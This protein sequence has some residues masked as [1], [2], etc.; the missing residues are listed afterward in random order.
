MKP[1]KKYRISFLV[2]MFC[3]VNILSPAQERFNKNKS[4]QYRVIH[5]T[6]QDGLADNGGNVMLKD[7]KGFLWV[8][9][10]YGE[11]CRFDGATFKKYIPNPRIK[12]M[13]NSGGIRALVED[14]LHHIWIGTSNGISKYDMMADTFSNFIPEFD[15]ININSTIIPFWSTADKVYCLESEV[16]IISYNIHSHKKTILFDR[17]ELGKLFIGGVAINSIILDAVSNSFWMLHNEQLGEAALWQIS[18]DDGKKQSYKWPCYSSNI[19]HRHTAEAIRFDDRRNSIWINSGEGLLE[20]SLIDKQ[21][22]RIAAMNE[23]VKLKDYDRYVGIDLDKFGRVWLATKPKGILIYDPQTESLEQLF[24]DPVLQEQTGEHNLHLYCDRDG[25]TWVSDYIGKGIYELLPFNSVIQRYDANPEIKGSL[26]NGSI[27]TTVAAENGKMWI[28]TE[29]GL[30]I[31][32][33]SK[34]K[35]EVLREKDLPGIKGLTIAPLYVDTVRQKAWIQARSPGLNKQNEMEMY[36][37][38]MQTRKCRPITFSDGLKKLNTFSIEPTWINPYQNGFLLFDERHGVF[39][40]RGD[41]LVA[42][43]IIPFKASVGRFVLGNDHL[44]FLQGGGSGINFTFEKINGSWGKKAH[45]L[46]SLPWLSMLYNGIDHSYW[47]SFKYELVHYD[48]NFKI[49][50]KYGQEVGYNGSIYNMQ[51]DNEGNLWFT[52]VLNQIGR[53]NKTTGIITILTEAEGFKKQTFTWFSPGARD[54][55]GNIYF[56]AG[57]WKASGGGFDRIYPESYTS[58]PTSTVYFRSLAINHSPFSLPTGLNNLKALSLFHHQNNISIET[59]IIDYYSAGN[60]Q[61]RYQLRGE[62]KDTSWQYGPAYYSIRYEN[63][64]PGS[65][66]LVIQASNVNAEFNSP[67]KILFIQIHPPY[68]Q[69]LWFRILAILA[70]LGLIIGIVQ[71]RSGSLRRSNKLL[72]DKVIVRTNELKESLDELKQTQAQLIQREK[73]ASLGELTSGIAH[74][75]QNPLNFIN[76]FSEVNAEL[77]AELKQELAEGDLEEIKSIADDI[78]DNEKKIMHHGKRAD[79]IVKGMLQH[80]RSNNTGLGQKEMTDLKALVDESL[81][82]S[83]HTFQAGL[84]AKEKSFQAR[85]EKD[86]DSSITQI[87]IIPEDLGRVFI[88]VFNNAFYAVHAKSSAITKAKAESSATLSAVN[89][90]SIQEIKDQ[91]SKPAIAYQPTIAVSTKKT[92]KGIEI[93][94]EDNGS[95]IPEKIKDKIF[96]PFFTTK[97]TGL[98]TGLGLSMA[99]DIVTKTHSGELKFDSTEGLGT[100]F[101]IKLPVG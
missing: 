77:I 10:Y 69:T 50:N 56:G 73:M 94:I 13:I 60:G 88:N 39:E 3:L 82:L 37:M 89:E 98:G 34:D 59:G 7:I 83:Y 35:F 63:L 81:R 62:N 76:N 72:E 47:V 65:Y 55:R 52:N 86:F 44:L 87:N 9:S 95:G 42:D 54:S 71:V 91:I 92:P 79:N 14:S 41:S 67:E 24:S 58:L 38:D 49:L 28:G 57:T 4:D 80:S 85:L 1:S 12:G 30:N 20:F 99:Y 45:L 18:L 48:K 16:R 51:M 2:L 29:D 68:W 75:I 36:E 6:M 100:I 21:F 97:P 15:P 61:I 5:W 64:P 53:L 46:D 17:K 23:L 84:K 70:S 8:G 27:Y 33:P 93:K 26:S 74:E 43:L 66:Q 101:T 90:K 96:L 11:L 31:F 19:G 25:I 22:H 78:E 40:I 32:D